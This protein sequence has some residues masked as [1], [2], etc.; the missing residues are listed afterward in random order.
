MIVIDPRE[1]DEIEII[2]EKFLLASETSSSLDTIDI[3]L[4]M[5]AI[6]QKI[7]MTQLH[8]NYKFKFCTL[9]DS[10]LAYQNADQVK[11]FEFYDG[12]NSTRV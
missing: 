6:P 9:Q 8:S 1:V 11:A 3:T 5:R 4:F 7:T 2:L 12:L 10:L